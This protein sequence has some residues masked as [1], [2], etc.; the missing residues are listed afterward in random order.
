M[1]GFPYQLPKDEFLRWP[2]SKTM[3]GWY[4]TVP[5]LSAPFLCKDF[6]YWV[7]LPLIEP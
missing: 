6:G 5:F 2:V 3:K 4:C 1:A 7:A